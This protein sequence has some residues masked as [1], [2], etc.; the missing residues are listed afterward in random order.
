MA[1]PNESRSIG[2]LLGD[3]VSHLGRLVHSEIQLARAEVSEK[4]SMATMGIA[5]IAGAGIIMIAVLTVLLI[6]LALWL[7]G[8][9][10]SPVAAHF[11][12]ALIGAVIA[13]VL[14]AVG[15]N[16]LKPEKLKPRVTLQQ[17]ERDVHTAK[18]LAK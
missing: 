11:T 2:E 10:F 16:R 4:V 17:L 6:S 8:L 1:S 3:A 13:A 15:L 5:F 7:T 12:A 9:G 14:V 18:E